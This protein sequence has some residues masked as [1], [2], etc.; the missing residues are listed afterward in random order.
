MD[1]LELLDNLKSLDIRE[2]AIE[3][4]KDGEQEMVN[5]MEN[6]LSQGLR[7]DGT[8]IAPPY[9]PFTIMMKE[10]KSGL[11]SVTDVVTLF[12]TGSHYAKLYVD[13]QADFIEYGS[14]DVKSP[15]LQ[16]KYGRIYGLTEESIDDFIEDFLDERFKSKVERRIGLRF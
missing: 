2:L 15:A 13:V 8:D 11:S 14:K 7:A 9:T 3:A 10:Q 5:A 6:Q 16:K 12:D 4:A 1:V